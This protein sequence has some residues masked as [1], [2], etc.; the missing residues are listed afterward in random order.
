MSAAATPE[1]RRAFGRGQLGPVFS[2]FAQLLQAAARRDGVRHLVFVAR[3]GEFLR[4][5]Q[6]CWQAASAEADP[7]ALHYAYLSRRS[8]NLL[9]LERVDAAA[10]QRALE[11]RAGRPTAAALLRL[12]GV[13]VETLPAPLQSEIATLAPD[14]LARWAERADFQHE[15]TVQR[16]RLT[17]QLSAYLASWGLPGATDVAFV[18]IGWQGSIVR[19]LQQTLCAAGQRLRL[20]QLGHWSE[21][22]PL[23]DTPAHIE[24]L[25]GDWR[26]AR[27]LREAAIYHLALLL[28]A[29]CREHAP[30]VV[31]YDG[32][33]TVQPRFADAAPD[34]DS[35]RENALWREPIRAGILEAVAALGREPMRGDPSAWRQA[36]QRRLWRLAYFPNAAARQAAMGLRHAEGHAAGWS[37][38]LIV[39]PLPRPWRWPRA[40]V[41]GLA[42]PWRAGYLMATG[43]V[44][45]AGLYA[46]LEAGLLAAP[47][48]WRTGLRDMARRFGRID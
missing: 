36:A 27:S 1:A 20:Y 5:V 38:A 47:P 19:T 2:A 46:L 17:A 29:V 39:S 9:R 23:P 26:R 34:A 6:R 21:T 32:M 10:V 8:T 12:L 48:H 11:V 28:E 44:L 16:E 13:D 35:E 4:E 45:L 30:P 43:G 15:L 33:A 14:G 7:P 37:A 31:G 24:G 41:A 40:W 3:D 18:D 25:L 42:S 22:L